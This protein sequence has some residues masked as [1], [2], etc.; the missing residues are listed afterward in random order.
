[1]PGQSRQ[2]GPPG[3]DPEPHL[4]VR[5]YGRRAHR[6]V[7]HQWPRGPGCDPDRLDRDRPH[8]RRGLAGGPALTGIRAISHLG[9][10]VEDL[11]Q[12]IARYRSIGFTLERRWTDD[13]EG[14]EAAELS[15]VDA[16][17]ELMRPLRDDSPVGRF[18]ARRGEGVHHV[19]YSV[20]DV[21]AALAA[22]RA[23]GLETLDQLPRVGGGGRTRVGFVHPRSM[24]GVLVEFEAPREDA[25]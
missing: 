13:A 18:L 19:C 14:M 3:V 2:S 17:V 7:G 22:A 9:L 23:Q 21:A 15:S 25:G 24:G 11:D 10:A 6:R 4:R 5:G 12:A 16:R 8:Q 20:D 1:E